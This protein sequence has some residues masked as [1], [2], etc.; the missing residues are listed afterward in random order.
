MA[1]DVKQKPWEQWKQAGMLALLIIAGISC[2]P[3]SEAGPRNFGDDP[4][5][6][7]ALVVC[8][9]AE[10]LGAVFVLL[11]NVPNY[12][13]LDK[14]HGVFT[15]IV[16]HFASKGYVLVRIFRPRH[17]HC[18]GHTYRARVLPLFVRADFMDLLDLKPF[19]RFSFGGALQTKFPEL[20][21]DRKRN[22]SH[23]GTFDPDTDTI[24]FDKGILVPGAVVQLPGSR[25]LWRVQNLHMDSVELMITDRRSS[26]RITVSRGALLVV[27]CSEA[28][29]KVFTPGQTVTTIR[30]SGEPP[31]YGAPLFRDADG[32]WSSAL[33]DRSSLS[34]FSTQDLGVMRHFLSEQQCSQAIGNCAPTR[35]VQP[36]LSLI[37]TALQPLITEVI[38]VDPSLQLDDAEAGIGGELE[39]VDVMVAAP[40]EADFVLSGGV[41]AAAIEKP[42]VI[43]FIEVLPLVSKVVLRLGGDVLWLDAGRPVVTGRV[44]QEAVALLPAADKEKILIPSG[45]W[46]NGTWACHVVAAVTDEQHC[47]GTAYTLSDLGSHPAYPLASLAMAKVMAHSSG[48]TTAQDIAPMLDAS[49]SFATGALL[50]KQLHPPKVGEGKCVMTRQEV[51]EHCRAIE[52]QTEH[53]LVERAKSVQKDEPALHDKLMEWAG[54]VT[55][56]DLKDV[57]DELL[58]QIPVFDDPQLM[59]KPFSF[60]AVVATTAAF[61]PPK[62]P[63][64]SFEPQCREDLW[65]PD[66]RAAVPD[67]ATVED[68]IGAFYD[69]LW[70]GD[71][72]PKELS[73]RRPDTKCW[74]LEHTVP[75][76]RGTIWDISR[77]KHTPVDFSG[78]PSSRFRLDRWLDRF[79]DCDDQQLVSHL[80]HSVCSFS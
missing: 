70:S 22:H 56:T 44:R 59:F 67:L 38:R 14:V 8:D 32:I 9:A 37:S 13:D 62:Q 17:N 57:P 49:G 72:T 51:L 12:C 43:A 4:R 58:M 69:D 23:Y 16:Q 46:Y 79:I 61:E 27:N 19:H 64:T 68:D 48:F 31:G 60:T 34:D 55:V 28:E 53:S 66:D 50:A 11:E 77:S 45:L 39:A 10:A 71:Y 75:E 41:A 15:K 33:E 2:Q 24:R 74:G 65:M 73:K 40:G 78:T 63:E 36:V 30:A 18:G 29:Y 80:T 20:K 21:L 7:G 47:E 35:L 54:Q 5:A 52:V 1:G 76:A 3:F 26:Q 42:S 25:R 6:W